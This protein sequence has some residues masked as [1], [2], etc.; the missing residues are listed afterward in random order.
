MKTLTRMQHDEEYM[1]VKIANK[2]IYS[3]EFHSGWMEVSGDDDSTPTGDPHYRY[4][5]LLR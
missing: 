4:T 1:R 2:R 3:V 5:T